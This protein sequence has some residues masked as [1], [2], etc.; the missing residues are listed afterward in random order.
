MDSQSCDIIRKKIRIYKDT[1][2]RI[3]SLT[4]FDAAQVINI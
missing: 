3:F 2:S 4:I 1:G